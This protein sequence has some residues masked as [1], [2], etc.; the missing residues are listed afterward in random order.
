MILFSM[1]RQTI[2]WTATLVGLAALVGLPDATKANIVVI[3]ADDMGYECAGAYGGT[4][5]QTP[6][7]DRLAATGLRFQHCYSQPICTPSR[8]QL[9][10]G[11]YNQRNYIRFGVLDPQ[12][13]TFANLLQQAGYAT[14]VAGKWQLEGGFDGPYHFG[15]DT[16]CLWQ[17]TRRPGRYPNPGLEI[18]GRELDFDNGEYGPDIVSDYI[19]DF[20]EN[21]Q[22]EP[23]L[24]YYPMILP[25]WPFE[26]TPDSEDWG[27]EARGVLRGH[28]DPQYFDD[29]VAYTDKMVGKIV[30]TLD[31]TG[32]REETIILFTT[33]NGTAREITSKMGDR[34]VQGGKGT[35]TDAGTR[36]PLI[37][38]WP[39]QIEPGRVTDRLVDFTDLFPTVLDLAD[40]EP[41]ADLELASSSFLPTLTG[42]AGNRRNWVYCWYARNGGPDGQEFA[43]N[44]RF[45]L[46][47]DGRFFDIDQDVREQEPL[48]A[49]ERD[50]RAHHA[51]RKLQAVLD[52]FEGTREPRPEPYPSEPDDE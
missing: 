48:E 4:S 31:R 23:F 26:P 12:E 3:M 8:V 29:M 42:K 41:P 43:R 10:T 24:V 14:C 35:T 6:R 45:K 46:Y 15:F 40:V 36:V 44:Q 16:Y 38:N 27:P 33:D 22:N 52:R 11:I 9:M 20:I 51:Y 1:L 13:T 17:L 7:L 2:Q 19:C 37:V 28:G 21:H 39:G 30:D 18:N 49:E 25:H 47:R 50:A 5:Y 32:L 34:T